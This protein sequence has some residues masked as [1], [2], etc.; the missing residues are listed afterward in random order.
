MTVLDAIAS[1]TMRMPPALW[2]G[3]THLVITATKESGRRFRFAALSTRV[4]RWLTNHR[5]AAKHALNSP[6]PGVD[7]MTRDWETTNLHVDG[8]G[9]ADDCDLALAREGVRPF[10]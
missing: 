8:N 5:L 10:D 3:P 1:A 9:L 4:A 7:S 6:L 2:P